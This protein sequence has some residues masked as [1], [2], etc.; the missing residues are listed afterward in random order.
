MLILGILF[1]CQSTPADLS[2]VADAAPTSEERVRKPK[3]LSA[4]A[5]ADVLAGTFP[6]TVDFDAIGSLLGSGTVTY[7]WSFGDGAVASGANIA[8]HTYIGQGDFTAT[9]TITDTI[10]KLTSVASVVI[11]VTIPACPVESAP[12]RW[13]GV[14]DL[15]LTE[16]SGLT[17]SHREPGLWYTHEDSGNSPDIVVLDTT[18]ATVSTITVTDALSDF[19]D[20]SVAVDPATGESMIFLADIGDNALARPDISVFVAPEPDPYVDSTLA[21]IQLDLIYPWGPRNAETL[22]VDPLTADIFVITKKTTGNASAYVKRAPHDV[23]GTF[24]MESVGDWSS[25]AMTAT[26]GDISPDG[27]RIVVRDYTTTARLFFRDGY[28]PLEDA[29]LA[30]P[31]DITIQ[32]E[33]Q[34]EAIGFTNDGQGLVTVSEGYA[35]SLYYVAL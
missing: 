33:F 17:E 2:P 8:S 34:G 35:Q 30:A 19:E 9:V 14:D 25:L 20:I 28:L 29:F 4:V 18:G 23:G 27:S 12:V 16:L 15:G 22:I 11:D 7:A 21:P 1:A 26:G 6:L 24:V 32:G 13:G 3:V 31:C 5:H 10:S